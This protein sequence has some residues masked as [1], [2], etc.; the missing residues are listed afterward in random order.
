MKFTGIVG[1]I[2]P[3]LPL[4]GALLAGC[5]TGDD[6][7]NTKKD[8]AGSAAV[9]GGGT[10][11]QVAADGGVLDPTFSNVYATFTRGC[12]CH[13]KADKGGLDMT[14]Q[15]SAYT[16]LVGVPSVACPAFERVTA[17]D[18]EHSLLLQSL[19]HSAMGD[20][21]PPAMPKGTTATMM[22]ADDLQLVEAWIAAGAPNN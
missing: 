13:V 14:S 6:F 11:G 22:S 19:S 9:G 21:T 3:G 5:N 8:L 15:E 18:P 16:S 12:G 1:F 17:S 7:D 4:L 2:G 10:S 20:C